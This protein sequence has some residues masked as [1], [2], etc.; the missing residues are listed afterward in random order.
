MIL[1]DLPRETRQAIGALALYGL[2]CA[3]IIPDCVKVFAE[4]NRIIFTDSVEMKNI[5]ETLGI[6]VATLKKNVFALL[7]SLGVDCTGKSSH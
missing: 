2:V 7:E 4:A 3:M 5:A 1:N 6:D